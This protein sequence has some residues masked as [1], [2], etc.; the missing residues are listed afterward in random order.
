MKN[1]KKILIVGNM[2]YIGS[3]LIE[4]LKNRYAGHY[5]GGFDCGVFS[6][7]LTTRGQ[8]PEHLIDVQ[9]FGDVREFPEHILSGYGSIIYLAAISN[10]SMAREFE[11]LTDQIN[12]KACIAIAGMAKRNGV[13]HFTLASSCSV[14]GAGGNKPRAEN[15]SI[16]P[17]TDYARSKISAEKGLA[18]LADSNFII[19]CLRFATACGM[20]P[21]LR[22]DLVLNDFVANAI[23]FKKIHI[24][25]DGSPLRP[26]I[27]V[28]DMS[29]AFDWS[30]GRTEQNGGRFLVVNTGSN[31]WNYQI[32]DLAIETKKIF[33]DKVEVEINQNA[34]SDKRSYSVNFDLFRSLAPDYYPQLS[35]P[36]SIGHLQKGLRRIEFNDH[37]FR[38]SNLIRLVVLRNSIKSGTYRSSIKARL[39]L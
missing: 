28:H 8:I 36:E 35:L 17:L 27:D 5:L 24:L 29:R 11:A 21:R 33:G 26:L 34:E 37:N 32:K 1:N 18:P 3:V 20:S 10:D 2:G 7:C 15:D 4:Y 13:H 6:H 14:Y 23:V 9:H 31:K 25:S 38:G 22:L 12:R 19:T 16:N 30:C 39:T